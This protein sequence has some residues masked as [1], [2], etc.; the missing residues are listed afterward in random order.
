MM[1]PW[2]RS[3]WLCDS[4]PPDASP[5]SRGMGKVENVRHATAANLSSDAEETEAIARTTLVTSWNESDHDEQK[6]GVVSAHHAPS[7]DDQIQLSVG[8]V[9]AAKK[10]TSRTGRVGAAAA[11]LALLAMAPCAFSVGPSVWLGLAGILLASAVG[12]LPSVIAVLRGCSNSGK[13]AMI[14][15]FT[16]WT[17]IGWAVALVMAIRSKKS[18]E[19]GSASANA[20]CVMSLVFLALSLVAAMVPGLAG[21]GLIMFMAQ[22]QFL[23]P[24]WAITNFRFH[25]VRA[26][27]TPSHTMAP[28]EAL[29]VAYFASSVLLL[30]AVMGD[31][32]LIIRELFS[33]AQSL[34]KQGQ[35]SGLHFALFASG[36]AI[37]VWA[38]VMTFALVSSYFIFRL[39]N[40]LNQRSAKLLIPN[41]LPAA[42]F[43]AFTIYAPF[44][45]STDY[46][47][48][49]LSWISAWL[50]VAFLCGY[51]FMGNSAA[52]S[53]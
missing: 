46:I 32:A 39:S 25:Q 38:C 35:A 6:T 20:G 26:Q 14:N 37:L 34:A 11:V 2:V 45:V 33:Y 22:V 48:S 50:A 16:G 40:S 29:V 42:G 36:G 1:Y 8:S 23:S 49:S 4:W 18:N 7:A 12:I 3:D 19:D 27:T 31:S 17:V 24:H 9:T 13:I 28:W 51:Y 10:G 53:K 43:F 44:A 30:S 5:F 15:I 47:L 52:S 21:L 41:L